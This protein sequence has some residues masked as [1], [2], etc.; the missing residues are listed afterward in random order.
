MKKETKSQSCNTIEFIQ[1]TW[2]LCIKIKGN[3]K[4]TQSLAWCVNWIYLS[5]CVKYIWFWH[6]LTICA[7]FCLQC[8]LSLLLEKVHDFYKPSNVNMLACVIEK[9]HLFKLKFLFPL[10]SRPYVH[11]ACRQQCLGSSAVVLGPVSSV[12]SSIMHVKVG[13]RIFHEEFWSLSAQL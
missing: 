1:T 12:D 2:F 8:M 6:F 9:W 11:G 5:W 3:T 10:H 7:R 13:M 4:S